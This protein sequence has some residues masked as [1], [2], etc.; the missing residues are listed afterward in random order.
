MEIINVERDIIDT[1]TPFHGREGYLYVY[2]DSLIKIFINH[3]VI[4]NKINKV[5]L[6]HEIDLDIT[7]TSLVSINGNIVG[8]SMPYLKDYHSVDP[9]YLSKKK[10]LI[11]MHKLIDK[12]EDL[13]KK[14]IIYGDIRIGNILINKNLDVV[15]CDM[16]NVY[17]NGYGYDI[18]GNISKRYIDKFGIDESLDIYSFNLCLACMLYNVIEPV[19]LDFLR[20]QP[21]LFKKYNKDYMEIID[22]MI[23]L[24]DKDKIKRLI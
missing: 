3:D 24:K 15:L 13:H 18:L 17:I 2:K 12:L 1:Y 21:K 6:L 20:F 22:N 10:K 4:D 9:I 11:I 7:P 23:T 8:Y 16:D 14:G 5:K 19:V